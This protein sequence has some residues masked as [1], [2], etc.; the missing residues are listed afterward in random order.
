MKLFK[1]FWISLLW[2]ALI[3]VACA[4]PGNELN[5][6]S[7]ISIPYFDKIVHFGFY[8]VFSFLLMIGYVKFHS[9]VRKRTYIY[10]LNISA[11]YG[12]SIEM[13]QNAVFVN[14]GADWSDFIANVLGSVFGILA[15]FLLKSFPNIY[16][17]IY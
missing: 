16:K 12:G 3:L 11:I 10:P 17:N 7:L 4:I 15:F 9:K 1:N 14:R 5:K 6:V 2:A 13:L 8:F